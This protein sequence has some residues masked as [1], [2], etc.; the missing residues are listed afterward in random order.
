[1]RVFVLLIEGKAN[2]KDTGAITLPS[3]DDIEQAPAELKERFDAIESVDL[4]HV[5]IQ[6]VLS[7]RL[8]V[9]FFEGKAN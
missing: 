4:S 8:F 5:N 2:L 1:M 7:V 3:P 6:G 9:L